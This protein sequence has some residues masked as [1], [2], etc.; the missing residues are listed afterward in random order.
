LIDATVLA[1]NGL[2]PASR[3]I[4]SPGERKTMLKTSSITPSNTGIS[5][6]NRRTRY[7]RD[8]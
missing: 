3:L 2:L 8:T 1:G 7:R 4:G 6:S 5:S